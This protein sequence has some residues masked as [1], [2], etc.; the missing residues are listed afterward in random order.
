[1]TVRTG[2]ATA[3]P[4]TRTTSSPLR[5]IDQKQCAPPQLVWALDLDPM[6]SSFSAPLAVDGI[7]YF[8]V[9]YSVVHAVDAVS[10]KLLWTYDPGRSP[11]FRARS[12][13][14]RTAYAASPI[15][16]GR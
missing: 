15:G 10:G 6:I 9:G 12:P 4:P 14:R 16:R 8:A 1:M 13:V 7:L 2:W 3:V 5:Q 11:T